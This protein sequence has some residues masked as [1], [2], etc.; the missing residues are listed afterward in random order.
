MGSPPELVK[1]SPSG[2]SSRPRHRRV[3]AIFPTNTT[4]QPL[5]HHG[6]PLSS[7]RLVTSCPLSPVTPWDLCGLLKPKERHLPAREFI[8]YPLLFQTDVRSKPLASCS[9][10]SLVS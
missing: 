10:G 5:E 9:A 2:R 7:V 3:D 6:Q 1:P 8:F 4:E